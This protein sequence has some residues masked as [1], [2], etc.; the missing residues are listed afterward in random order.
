MIGIFPVN[1]VKK[2]QTEAL[3]LENSSIGLELSLDGSLQLCPAVPLGF[4]F[5]STH[6]AVP[7]GPPSE[8]SHHLNLNSR[9]FKRGREKKNKFFFFFLPMNKSLRNVFLGVILKKLSLGRS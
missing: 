6:K 4:L 7:W 9:T 5:P 8:L 2:L 3:P 1:T